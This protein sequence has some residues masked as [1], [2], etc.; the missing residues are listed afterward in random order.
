METAMTFQNKRLTGIVFGVGLLL[1]IPFTAMKFTGEVKW[2]PF[3]FVVAGVLLLGTGLAIEIV[4]RM[5][6][7]LEYRLA[8]CAAILLVL[9]I[10]WAELAV[11][12]IGTPLAGS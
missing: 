8:I 10:V 4:L 2:S 5:V 6:K 12:I 3:D 9:F 11:G 1:L 7:R